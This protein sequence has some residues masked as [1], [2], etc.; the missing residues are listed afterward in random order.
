MRH[1]RHV[2]AGGLSSEGPAESCYLGRYWLEYHQFAPWKNRYGFKVPREQ[3]W[4]LYEHSFDRNPE[5]VRFFRTR[6][7][8]EAW[9]MAR[10]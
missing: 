1:P 3:P 6:P 2:Y 7:E 8:A 4:T 9:V 10:P 5:P